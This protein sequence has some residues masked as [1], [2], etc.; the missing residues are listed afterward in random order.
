MAYGTFNLPLGKKPLG[1]KW[2]YK[3]K[4]NSDGSTE[5]FKA[6]LVP[7]EYNQQDGIDYIET[8]SHVVKMVTI[9]IVLALAS[10]YN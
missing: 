2:L 3:V 6:K 10:I 5:S 1:C 9:R 8:F 4:H 7:K